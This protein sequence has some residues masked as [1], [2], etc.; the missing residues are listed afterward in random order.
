MKRIQTAV[1]KERK[2]RR[3]KIIMGAVLIFLMVASTW[4]YSLMSK[5]GEDSSKVEERGLDFYKVDG[6]WR[7][8]ID[9]QVFA[10]QYLPSEVSEV[11]VGGLH[12][13]GAYA[14]QPLMGIVCKIK[15]SW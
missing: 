5:D 14:N 12:D 8:T 7:T 13:V 6:L 4:G 2:A 15:I 10:F 11:S 9:E 3:G 1:V